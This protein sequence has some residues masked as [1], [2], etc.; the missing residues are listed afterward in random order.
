[1]RHSNGVIKSMS[2]SR[3]VAQPI[4]VS[5][6]ECKTV[7]EI[8][9]KINALYTPYIPHISDTDF[10]RVYAELYETIKSAMKGEKK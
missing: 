7:D 9:G 10:N 1:M 3:V 4:K 6:A 8:V 2:G 5:H